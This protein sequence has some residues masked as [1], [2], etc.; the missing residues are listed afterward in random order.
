MDVQ[1]ADVAWTKYNMPIP[2]LMQT[3]LIFKPYWIFCSTCNALH[4]K[5]LCFKKFLGSEEEGGE[6]K[7]Q[8]L[9]LGLA[10]T[11]FS[12]SPMEVRQ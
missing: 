1:N 6:D 8:N 10:I 5:P 3:P 2:L 4:N 7:E 11:S 12:I 9:G